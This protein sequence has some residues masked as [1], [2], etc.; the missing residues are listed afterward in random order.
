MH[1]RPFLVPKPEKND[2]RSRPYLDSTMENELAQE[3]TGTIQR[4]LQLADRYL[5]LVDEEADPSSG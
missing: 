3:Q 2:P 5:D 4:Y 1:D